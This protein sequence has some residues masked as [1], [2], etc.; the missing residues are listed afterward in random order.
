MGMPGEI[1]RTAGFPAIPI[2]MSSTRLHEKSQQ[3]NHKF[4]LSDVV[5]LVKALNAPVAVFHYG[6]SAMN[7]I[8]DVEKGGKHFL[9]GVHFKQ[10]REGVEVSSVRGIFPRIMQNG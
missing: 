6:N 5:D 8:V 4:E 10:S 9:V 7:V 3:E 1:L 2:E